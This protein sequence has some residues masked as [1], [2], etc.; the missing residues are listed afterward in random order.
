LISATTPFKA[1][2]G[3]PTPPVELPVGVGLAV[4]GTELS[5]TAGAPATVDLAPLLGGVGGGDKHFPF[6]QQVAVAQWDITHNLG[7]FPSV[8]IADNSKQAIFPGDIIY[9]SLNTLS[10]IFSAPFSGWAYLN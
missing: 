7:K 5:L 1:S 9:T 3:C 8:A 2:R 10:L 6:E 4:N